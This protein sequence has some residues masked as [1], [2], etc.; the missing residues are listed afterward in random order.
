LLLIDDATSHAMLGGSPTGVGGIYNLRGSPPL[1]IELLYRL[2][3][4]HCEIV[5]SLTEIVHLQQNDLTDFLIFQD[6]FGRLHD[7]GYCMM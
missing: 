2:L 1:L 3:N 7:K 5:L 4:E 6:S